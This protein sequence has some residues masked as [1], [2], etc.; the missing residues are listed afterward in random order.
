MT[1]ADTE[2]RRSCLYAVI[3]EEEGSEV[4]VE[5]AREAASVGSEEAEAVAEA[6]E[7]RGDRI[8]PASITYIVLCLII[9]V[10]ETEGT[11][12]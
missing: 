11:S 10:G 5:A 3:R 7:D 6:P 2:F 12:A 4:S 1:K 8:T 9:G